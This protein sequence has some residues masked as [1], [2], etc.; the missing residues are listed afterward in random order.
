MTDTHD[1]FAEHAMLGSALANPD[2]VGPILL[3][4]PHGAFWL[5]KNQRIAA[6]ITDLLV[7]EQ[8][9]DLPTVAR[10]CQGHRDAGE[11]V[12]LY[13]L[14]LMERAYTP[15]NAEYY[16]DRIRQ[17]FAA[18]S[19]GSALLRATQRLSE[20][21]ESGEDIDLGPITAEL[22]TAT[23][24]AL[25]AQS[26]G[27]VRTVPTV[28]DLLDEEITYDW[29]VPGLL[30]RRERLI[31]T[32]G[33]GF[34]K[35]VLMT[36]LATCLAAGLHP[37]T[38]QPL[39]QQFRMLVVD[40]ENPKGLARRR[41][42]EML[43]LVEEIRS[44]VRESRPNWSKQLHI[45]F[46]PDGLDLLESRDC[47]W[48][49]ATVAAAAPDILAIGPIYKLH[50]TNI[51]DELA[52]RKLTSFLDGLRHRHGCALLSE[53]HAGVA[54][55]SG[56]RRKMRPVG[57]SLFMRWPEFG[58]GMVRAKDAEGENPN[59]VDMIAW[60]GSREERAWPRQLMYGGPGEL[61]WV[62]SN[63]GY[64]HWANSMKGM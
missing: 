2:H 15:L 43:P 28:L 33:E 7:R 46:R 20:V 4:L 25:S 37:F 41:Y 11:N 60:R 54:E 36:Q 58:Y 10:R 32:G 42:R 47:N 40:C 16:A 53:A 19:L 63:P 5:P 17:C 18:R 6:V 8:A 23:A 45:E 51:N 30:E 64:R 39:H 29:L 24:E 48:L 56:G 26:V 35:S 50:Q 21:A 55:D 22:A 57:T 38:A 27:E 59:L 31:V 13:L 34:G 12:H 52:G 14:N 3:A 61:P 62:P 1:L 49:E 44:G 9:V